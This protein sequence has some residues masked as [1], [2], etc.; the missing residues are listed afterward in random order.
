VRAIAAGLL[1]A[2]FPLTAPAQTTPAAART[3]VYAFESRQA[4]SADS[5][6]E[7]G[8][9]PAGELSP[10]DCLTG[11]LK[12]AGRMSAAVDAG[13]GGIDWF[14]T[15]CKGGFGYHLSA[16]APPQRGTIHVAVV[17]EQP[18]Q[19]LVVQLSE[20]PAPSGASA[21]TCVVYPTTALICDPNQPVSLEELTLLRFL[22]PGLVDPARDGTHWQFAD[23]GPQS[24]FK[25][26]YSVL[27]SSAGVMTIGERR[28]TTGDTG[29]ESTANS[30]STILYDTSRAIPTAIDEN[31]IQKQMRRG[32]YETT[33]H[34]LVFQLQTPASR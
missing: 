33:R 19:T 1:I 25:A 20:S 34:D 6:A 18:D 21:A 32:R 30:V 17:R 23:G 4:E 12:V 3:L 28:T 13:N 22:S 10:D 31:L 5:A 29:P 14:Q 2:A 9:R 7:T 26:S 16:N 15:D 11:G 27:Q 24:S 8:N